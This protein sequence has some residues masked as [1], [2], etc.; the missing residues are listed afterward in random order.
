ML[1]AALG[2]LV[3]LLALLAGCACGACGKKQNVT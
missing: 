1:P 2:L 3:I